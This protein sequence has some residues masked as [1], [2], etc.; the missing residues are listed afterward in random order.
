MSWST[1]T[2]EAISLAA[3]SPVLL[4]ACDYD[5]TVAPIVDDPAR[6][7]PLRAAIAGLRGLALL[8]DTHV[9]VISGRSLADLAMLSR[10]PDEV[11]LIGSHGSEFEP[12]SM[13]RLEPLQVALLRRIESEMMVVANDVRGCSVEAKPAGVAFH[14]RRADP[15]DVEGAL[16]RV[17]TGPGS[18]DGVH[19]RDGKCVVELSVV[20]TDKGEAL[21]R[22]R[23]AVGAE[24]VVFLGDDRTD[25]DA[26]AQLHGPDVSITVGEGESLATFRVDDPEDAAGVLGRLFDERAAWVAGHRAPKIERHSL[27]SDQ[28]TVALVDPAGRISWMC[29]PRADSQAVFAELLGGPTAGFFVVRPVGESA[30]PVQRYLPD[31]MLVETQWRTHRVTDYLDV[32]DGRADEPAGRS[33][34]IRVIEGTG[35]IEVLFAPRPD[36]GRNVAEVEIIPGGLQVIGGLEPIVLMA[37]HVEWEITHEGGL[38]TA[39]AMV[40]PAGGAVVLNLCLG[41]DAVRPDDDE[42]ARREGTMEH[43]RRI[44]GEYRVPVVATALVRRSALTLEALRY[45]PSG[46]MV[47]AATTSLPEAIGGPRNWDYRYCWPRDSS[48]ACASLARLGRIEP[49]LALL[50]WLVDR[51]AHA[52]R[53]DLL[54][55]LYHVT[56]DE[57]VPEG[58]ISE[59]TGYAGSRPVRIGNAAE[60][61]VQLDALG[62]VVDLVHQ[63]FSSG[64]G[65]RPRHWQL[66]EQIVAVVVDQWR[67]PD[68]GIWEVR[69]ARQ[70]N[71][72][73]KVMCWQ[74]LD[75]AIRIAEITGREVPENW[76]VVR[77]EIVAEVVARGWNAELDSF[78]SAYGGD[79]LD[80]GLLLMGT[81]GFIDPHDPRFESTVRAIEAELCDGPAVYRY[82]HE[83]GLAGAE[84]G[85]IICTGWLIQALVACGRVDEA[86]D[87]FDRLVIPAG[88]TGLLPEQI[89]PTTE[90]GLGNFPQAYSHLALIDA[91]CALEAGGVSG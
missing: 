46:A 71:V 8:P 14:Y 6:A 44:V 42:P 32:S 69:L 16:A 79:S 29:H 83:D 54:R 10:L 56:G 57:P 27:L 11:H 4:V 33:N 9:A 50:D 67:N 30:A 38:Q 47:A 77:R 87:W 59:L 60:N 28:R 68:H 58:T 12:D 15:A 84:G 22:V 7:H 19:I 40:D 39:R 41:A 35:P 90:H 51:I 20:D 63:I 21:E 25:E 18:L 26:F 88:P 2:A 72:V 55:P 53:P 49:G 73:S 81:C 64:G 91:A 48:M 78:V 75:R 45:R 37:E 76:H 66:T 34:L 3:R 82:R 62:P 65:L 43:W 86:H 74:V 36:F 70:H 17:M 85:M 61:Q 5:G 89:D 52:T 80:A 24:T 1:G 23:H 31:T 13:R